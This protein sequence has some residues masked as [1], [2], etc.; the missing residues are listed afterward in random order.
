MQASWQLSQHSGLLLNARHYEID[1]SSEQRKDANISVE[2]GVNHK[3][4]PN[5]GISASVRRIVRNST[6]D[7]FDIEENRIWL[8]YS[9]K[10]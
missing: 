7:S 3:L 10:F 5:A 2:F 6:L 1:Y 4:N 8:T 9:H